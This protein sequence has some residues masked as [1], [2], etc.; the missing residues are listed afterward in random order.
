MK[1]KVF[2][3]YSHKQKEWVRDR[4]VPCLEAG[5]V[6]VLIDYKCFKAGRTVLGQ[7]DSTQDK[8]DLH[9]LVLSPDYLNSPSC[10]HEMDRAIALDPTFQQGI[11]IPIRLANCP[12]PEKIAQPNRR[13]N[14]LYID[15]KNDT[16]AEQ[17]DALM[18]ACDS[19]LGTCASHW[20]EVRDEIRQH[21]RNARSVSLIVE[22]KPK[23]REL[24]ENLRSDEDPAGPLPAIAEVDLERGAAVSRRGLVEEIIRKFGGAHAVPAEPEDLVTLDRYVC[25]GPKR[26]LVLRHFD[27]VLHRPHYGVDFFSTLRYL[28]TEEK[29]LL[30]L[31]HSRA[32]L[33]ALLPETHPLSSCFTSLQTT[34]LKGY[35]CVE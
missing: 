23:W 4:L 8:A 3:S 33:P 14:P 13:D 20:L 10:R 16:D 18:E 15:L 1:R 35:A 27:H 30:L 9:I 22:G 26:C 25:Q 17:W 19:N 29:K 6:E 7:M 2:V 5:G 34:K 28:M 11:V 21:L 31:F 24:I 32:P 12:L